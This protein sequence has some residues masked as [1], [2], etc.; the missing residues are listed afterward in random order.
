[1]EQETTWRGET[2]TQEGVTR[3]QCGRGAADET[4]DSIVNYV[5]PLM[6][7]KKGQKE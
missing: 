5:V 1:M 7:N 2:D 4:K 6:T 3:G